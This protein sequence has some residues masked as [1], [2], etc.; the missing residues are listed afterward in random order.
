[1]ADL[2]LALRPEDVQFVARVEDDSGVLKL[3]VIKADK[4]EVSGVPCTLPFA[5]SFGMWY[6]LITGRLT[7]LDVPLLAQ[8]FPEFYW[9]TWTDVLDVLRVRL[10]SITSAELNLLIAKLLG[11]IPVTAVVEEVRI[12]LLKSPYYLFDLLNGSRSPM[13]VGKTVLGN[14]WW[15]YGVY[16]WVA[17][18]LAKKPVWSGSVGADYLPGSG[19]PFSSAKSLERLFGAVIPHLRPVVPI[20]PPGNAVLPMVDSASG[21]ALADSAAIAT[22]ASASA[23]ASAA[24][25]VDV[26]AKVLTTTKDLPPESLPKAITFLNTVL[27][28]ISSVAKLPSM[29][30]TVKEPLQLSAALGGFSWPHGVDS[31]RVIQALQSWLKYVEDSHLVTATV[32]VKQRYLDELL[33]LLPLS[34]VCWTSL[35]MQLMVSLGDSFT[36]DA[37]EKLVAVHDRPSM[38]WALAELTLS[39]GQTASL[40]AIK[41]Q[42]QRLVG[43]GPSTPPADW[44]TQMV[45][46]YLGKDN[47][48]PLLRTEPGRPSAVPSLPSRPT[49]NTLERM[50][51]CLRLEGA[52]PVPWPALQ[53]ALAAHFGDDVFVARQ[54]NP[55][56]QYIYA[57]VGI[58]AWTRTSAGRSYWR[59]PLGSGL[60]AT[61]TNK[62]GNGTLV[63]PPIFTASP[64]AVTDYLRCQGTTSHCGSSA[65]MLGKRQRSPSPPAAVFSHPPRWSGP[66]AQTSGRGSVVSAP[67]FRGG[68]RALVTRGWPARRG[69]ANL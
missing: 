51:I 9:A 59:I 44:A 21:G 19:S 11:G 43:S 31:L 63:E 53:A 17:T 3:V 24:T 32:S 61:V 7:P 35:A 33:S 27:S 23:E 47:T 60:S 52:A 39:T 2:L 68:A 14:L 22:S 29:L 49:S 56:V 48:T 66:R 46:R 64:Q 38:A 15:H 13:T 42:L 28:A 50:G 54:S 69:P 4:V 30:A 8:E 41:S 67:S 10:E 37:L 65:A 20:R 55:L 18:S 5:Q 34:D 40:K 6:S 45:G 16:K 36:S 58:D 25:F 57:S 12:L 26:L 1:M 62:R